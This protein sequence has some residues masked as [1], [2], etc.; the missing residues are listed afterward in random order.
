MGEGNGD[1]VR[2][3][4]TNGDKGYCVHFASSA[5]VL[6]RAAGIPARYVTGYLVSASQWQAL[7]SDGYIAPVMDSNA[8]AWA[9]YY[10]PGVGWVVL[11]A[12]P[13]ESTPGSDAQWEQIT[14]PE[15][16][17]DL[18][19]LLPSC[20]AALAV[21]AVGFLVYIQAKVFLRRRKLNHGTIKQ[22][23]LAHW[24]EITLLCAA[25]DQLPDSQLF[26]LAQEA[27]FSHHTMD[28]S[29]LTPFREARALALE[30]LR[31]LPLP[32][33]LLLRFFPGLY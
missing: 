31:K 9:E 32:R 10:L 14:T 24:Q 33:R 12:T 2:W 7:G 4:L 19:W 16:T 27:K 28:E 21:A 20:I 6:L 15:Q 30:E 22:K 17:L 1:F 8:H 18:S 3:F 23:I 13:S 11:E 29:S 26:D 5:V 25:L